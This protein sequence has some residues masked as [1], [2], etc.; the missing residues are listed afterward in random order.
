M[1]APRI[2]PAQAAAEILAR[3]LARSSFLE[4]SR[5]IAPEEPPARHHAL[6]CQACDDI[7][8]GKIRRLMIFMP[9][10]S[11]KS[12]YASVRFPAYFLGR[13]PDK[14]IICTAYGDELASAFGRRVRNIV[15]SREYHNLFEITLSEDSRAKGEWETSRGGCYFAA[16]VGGG[17]TGRRADLGLIDDP[18]KGREEA[19]S[20]TIQRKTW[21]W[22]RTDFVTRLKPGASQIIIQTRWNYN[23]LS[24]MILPQDWNGE[25]GVFK[26]FD[27]SDW[28]V[29]CLPAQARKNDILGRKEG[30]WLW[31]EYFTEQF[32]KETRAA[33]ESEDLRNWMSLYQQIPQE[34]KGS[35]F[36]REWF[37]FVD[38][39]DIPGSL[40]RCG[41]SDYAVTDKGGDYT[42]HGIFGVD[43]HGNPYILDW[44][45]ER[46]TS[47][48]WIETQIHLI[49]KHDL[50]YWIGE[51]GQIQRAVEP[52]LKMRMDQRRVTCMME[53]LPSIT[54]KQSRAR[55]F[56]ALAATRGVV[57]P[58]A[59]WAYRLVDELVRFP[60]G[61]HDDAIDVCSLFG[62]I[63]HNML[64]YNPTLFNER[65][66]YDESENERSSISGY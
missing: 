30:E 54:D 27:G 35:F 5:Y 24:G 3:K 2:T 44:W 52:F 45:Y 7:I 60:M 62:R 34:E 20:K 43:H 14:N 4:F 37:R 29:I 13:R 51:G 57:L 28:T 50:N 53:W 49:F 63:H 11:A 1:A 42:E 66:Q 41:C 55:S 59:D 19:D 8:D 22:Y 26:G 36:K 31:P 12:T 39:T 16:G 15:A 65:E 23:D 58:K 56:Q 9:P 25:S 40:N 33:Q 61:K 48:A 21:D 32:W 6:I 47:D 46:T 64:D 18:V 17:I 10:G 38:A